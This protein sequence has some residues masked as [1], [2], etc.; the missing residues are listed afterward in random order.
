[1][2]MK[3]K[4]KGFTFVEILVLVGVFSIIAGSILRVAVSW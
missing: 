4:K 1:M 3:N 2:L